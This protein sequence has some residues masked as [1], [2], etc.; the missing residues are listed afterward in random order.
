MSTN[1]DY[2]MLGWVGAPYVI[3]NTPP[4]QPMDLIPNATFAM[5]PNNN[6]SYNSTSGIITLAPGKV[7]RI[8]V[9][10]GANYMQNNGFSTIYQLVDVANNLLSPNAEGLIACHSGAST[11]TQSSVNDIIF[12]PSPQLNSFKLRVLLSNGTCTLHPSRCSLIV[13]SLY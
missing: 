7:Y 13:Q 3:P 10:L 9:R 5:G 1:T 11:G 2:L 8:T 6:I 4:N 12:V